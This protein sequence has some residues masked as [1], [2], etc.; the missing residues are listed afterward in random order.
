MIHGG[1]FNNASVVTFRAVYAARDGASVWNASVIPAQT[2]YSFTKAIVP[3]L[4]APG[5]AWISVDDGDEFLINAGKPWWVQGDLGESASPGG[6]L[7]VLGS[8]MRACATPTM[9]RAEFARDQHKIR[10]EMRRER[11]PNRVAALASDLLALSR[12]MDS[13]ACTPAVRLTP[14]PRIHGQYPTA[15]Q[16]VLPVAAGNATDHSFWVSLPA[17]MPFGDYA[18]EMTSDSAQPDLWVPLDEFKSQEEPIWTSVTI[19]ASPPSFDRQV[20]H[21]QAYG[22]LFPPGKRGGGNTSD[23]ALNS[24]LAA[25]FAAGGGTVLVPPGAVFVTGPILIPPGVMLAGAAANETSI[26]VAEATPITAPPAYFGLQ[27]AAPTGRWGLRDL[28]IYVSAFHN[29]V[30]QATNTTERLEL[31][32][33]VIRANAFMGGNGVGTSTRNRNITWSEESN[34][35]AVDLRCRNFVILDCDIM[36]NAAAIN[37][38]CHG[39]TGGDPAC[40]GASWGEIRGNALAN[41]AGAAVFMNQWEQVIFADNIVTGTSLIAGGNSVGTGPGG[42]VAQHILFAHNELRN[43]RGNDREMIT[44]D[45]AGGSYYGA[46]SSANGTL[47]ETAED[48]KP[49]GSDEWG[50]WGGGAVVV[51]SGPGAGQY[52]RIVKP[53]ASALPHPGNRT[54]VVDRPFSPALVPNQSIVEIEPYRGRIIF[55]DSLLADGGAI[56]VYG[57]GLETLFQGIIV[58]RATAFV[59]WGQWRGWTPAD[60]SGVMGNGIQ[61]NLLNQY[62]DNVV[63]TSTGWTN[64]N[65]SLTRDYDTFY[66][67]SSFVAV[68][69]DSEGHPLPSPHNRGLVFRGNLG[70]GGVHIGES[71]ADVLVENNQP[72]SVMVDIGTQRI[73]V[74]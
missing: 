18:V 70:G 67:S 71:S 14:V 58:E 28:T 22:R 46:I 17:S 27:E 52:R 41:G 60:V 12:M 32:R 57:H 49:A 3:A 54:W 43:V 33:V 68:P 7:W 59:A 19:E 65:S 37:S 21:A 63:L 20:F 26:F 66:N 42:G 39:S 6:Y 2:S 9:P 62:L 72:D 30:V 29:A 48:C 55:A 8:E 25:A 47:V 69:A 50:G 1:P 64:Y 44:F 10:S 53:G 73:L 16:I 24:A 5:A 15:G 31:R 4:L 74:S 38:M 23:A 35:H 40:H 13:S 56:Q 36:G 61:P 51:V 34:G 45:D 11:R